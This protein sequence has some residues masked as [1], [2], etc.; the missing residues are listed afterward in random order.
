MPKRHLKIL[1]YAAVLA[2]FCYYGTNRYAGTLCHIMRVVQG[3]SL[4]ACDPRDLFDHALQGMMRSIDENSSYIPPKNYEELNETLSQEFGGLGI[5]VAM[6]E[7]KQNPVIR[8]AY[9][10]SPAA[11][12]GVQAGDGIVSVDGESVANRSL[13]EITRT[14]RGPVGTTVILGLK[15]GNQTLNL[16]M[17]RDKIH[18]E[19][20]EGLIRR[21]DGTWDYSVPGNPGLIFLRLTSF[22]EKTYEE[23]YAV[24]S[25]L[26]E[27]TRGLILDL[28]DNSGGLLDTAIRICD[29]FVD[30]GILVTTRGREGEVIQEFPATAYTLWPDLPVAVLI[31][32][33]SA[34]ASEILA[35]CLQDHAQQGELKAICVGERS[36]GKG[37]VQQLIDLGYLP[38]DLAGSDDAS[39]TRIPPLWKRVW[40]PPPR[41]ALRLTV[42]SYWRPNGKN[43]H[44]FAEDTDKDTWGV[45]PNP[46]FVVPFHPDKAYRQQVRDRHC[47]TLKP[48]EISRIV[49]SDPQLQ[50]AVEWIGSTTPA[51]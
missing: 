25:K 12:A 17:V 14:L 15:R 36:Y 20:V 11:K 22:G 28:R 39:Q 9:P 6:A 51:K 16:S 10:D 21:P 40:S 23:M 37:T 27:E 35:A 48:E 42:A 44:R 32:G 1:F 29:L 30:R 24:L 34:S 5:Y 46:G 49:P 18:V 38:G 50:K 13:D 3:Q 2:L 41:G 47:G 43:I 33:G 26:P 19:T 4:E 8:F 45:V 7:N 31:N